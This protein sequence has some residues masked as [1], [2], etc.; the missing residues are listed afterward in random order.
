MKKI[1][2]LLLVLSVSVG[3]FAGIDFYGQIRTG[4]WYQ[5]QNEDYAGGEARTKMD[6]LLYKNSRLG[7]NFTSDNFF[8]KAE[9]GL[10]PDVHVSNA[11]G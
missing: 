4:L 7:F 9:I 2:V 10:Y 6:F 5:L 1:I 11:Y 8:A 3:L